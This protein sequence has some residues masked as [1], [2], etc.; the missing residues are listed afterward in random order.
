MR[1]GHRPQ[2]VLLLHRGEVPAQGD[3]VVLVVLQ[4]HVDHFHGEVHP[5]A[6]LLQHQVVVLVLHAHHVAV[7]VTR[8]IQQAPQQ[9]A[10]HRPD[11]Q[12]LLF[13]AQL[14]QHHA[15]GVLPDPVPQHVQ[16]LERHPVAV[17]VADAGVHHPHGGL[18]RQGHH[19]GDVGEGGP[20]AQRGGQ[21]QRIGFLRAEEA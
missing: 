5:P 11:V 4:F 13:V 12:H 18:A 17:I 20:H 15:R 3:R 2:D 19:R 16:V 14:Q 9:R 6:R 1:G 21:A 8:G 10:A 7:H